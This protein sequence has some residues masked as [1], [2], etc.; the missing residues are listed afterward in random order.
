MCDVADVVDLQKAVA[1]TD[2][3]EFE[4]ALYSHKFLG[5]LWRA[6]R[7]LLAN[8][9]SKFGDVLAAQGRHGSLGQGQVLYV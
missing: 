5:R 7:N 8:W 2:E 3:L 6:S 9:A 1:T 4:G